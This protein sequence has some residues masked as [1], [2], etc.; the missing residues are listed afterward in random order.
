MLRPPIMIFDDS[1]AAIDAGTERHIRASL[2]EVTRQC[3]TIIIAHR[4]SSLMHADE[5]LFLDRGRVV[6]RGSHVELLAQGGRYAA[7]YELQTRRSTGADEQAASRDDGARAEGRAGGNGD[8]AADELRGITRG[9]SGG[10]PA[11][12][13]EPSGNGRGA[14]GADNG[15]AGADLPVA[16]GDHAPPPAAAGQPPA[17]PV[18]VPGGNGA[19]AVAHAEATGGRS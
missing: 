6:E 12:M 2:R 4:L 17:T 11:A 15:A 10:G 1:T 8:A 9:Q 7:L 14:P 16:A 5:I 19:A 13:G 18:A 3:A